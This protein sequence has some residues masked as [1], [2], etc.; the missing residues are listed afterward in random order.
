[1]E[2]D[3]AEPRGARIRGLAEAESGKTSGVPPLLESGFEYQRPRPGARND[4]F[5]QVRSI[6][7]SLS[8]ESEYLPVLKSASEHGLARKA[9]VECAGGGL[10]GR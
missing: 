4:T 7:Q 1:M 10:R 2:N 8:S 9:G 6:E 5:P 3:Q